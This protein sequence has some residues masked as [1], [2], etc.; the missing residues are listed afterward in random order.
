MSTKGKLTDTEVSDS[1]VELQQVTR[2][3][4]DI[5]SDED[6]Q[7]QPEK[8]QVSN[9]SEKKIRRSERCRT[10]T[11]KGRGMQEEKIKGLKR[12]FNFAYDKWKYSVKFARK[13]L[14]QV[15]E[16]LTDDELHHIISEDHSY[17]ADVQR[18]YDEL[19]QIEL[20]DQETRRRVDLCIQVSN[21][22]SHRAAKQLDGHTFE[23]DDGWPEV[24]SLFN[25][26]VCSL[27]SG[28][29]RSSLHTSGSAERRQEAAAE[30]AASHAV[31]KV[32]QE[33]E[34]EQQEIQRL[35]EE[36]MNKLAEQEA[37]A[38]KRRLEREAEELKR[39]IQIEEEEA[40]IKAQIRAEHAALQRTLDERKRKVQQLET[41]KSLSA[42]QARIEVYDQVEV[43][44]EE[45]DIL[46]G[47]LRTVKQVPASTS[48][49]SPYV[50]SASKALMSSSP[51]STAELVKVLA[52]AVS[53]N[54]IPIPEPVV[55]KG[56]PLM[57]SDWK[58]SF[59]ALIEKKNIN[60]NEKLYY[61]RRYVDG[62]ARKAIEGYFLLG[63]PSAYVAAWELLDERYG[64]PFTIAQSYRDKLH[65]W[66][67]IGPKESLQLRS[68]TDFL[69]SCEAAITHIKALG[70]LN[71]CNENR[72]I[73]SKLPD[74][75]IARWNRMSVEMEE[76]NGHF[77]TFSQF[78]TFLM[79]EVKIACHPITSLQ[80]VK[81]GDADT[82]S[83][84]RNQ[85]M[86]AKVLATNIDE[87]D[88]ITCVFC[89]KKGHTLHTCRTFMKDEVPKRTSFVKENKLCFGCLKPGHY[90]K[91]CSSR[92]ECDVCHKRHP[93][94]L[95]EDRVKVDKNPTQT[96]E[97]Q[98]QGQEEPERVPPEQ[99]TTVAI[100]HRAIVGEAGTIT[101]AILPV[102]LSTTTCPAEEVLVYALL[103]SQ[104]DST[105]I[106]SEVADTLKAKK[107]H[108]KLKLTT[109]TTTSTVNSQK[110]NNL[111][112]RG[113]YSR[114]KISLPP[115]YTREFIPANR[116]HIPT[117]EN[118]KAWSH[119]EHLQE[120]IAPL[121]DCQ[122]GLLI[123]YNCSQALLPREVVSGK[124]NQPYAQR[125]D[126]GWSIVGCG[127]PC[128][129]YGD[130]IGISH[131]MEVRQ[132]TP[133]IESSTSF[134]T[135]VHY[136]S[137]IKV[138]EVTAT[139]IIKVLESDF[140]E[141]AKEE[142]PISQDDLKFL[143]KPKES[144][145]Q[146]VNGHYE[147]PLPFRE[148]RP[149]LPINKTSTKPEQWSYIAS[150][151]FVSQRR[152]HQRECKVGEVSKDDQEL[153]KRFL[154]CT[155]TKEE[156]SLRD[157]LKKFLDWTISP[158]AVARVKRMTKH[159]GFKQRTNVYKYRRKDRSCQK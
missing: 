128:V 45:K 145:T 151:K 147:M 126:L 66:P 79:K 129:D 16:P 110:V 67:K 134:R 34:R 122:V 13:K 137:R 21:F 158:Q 148:E 144:I 15:T 52:D 152:S 125:T 87:K 29:K 41:M 50:F 24:G 112:I 98:S 101:S 53:T 131:H 12:R 1:E 32:S 49:P 116:D 85:T 14:V 92:S 9:T 135:E 83:G 47:E 115:A 130:A 23:E 71:D 95:H 104:S 109:M 73:L 51:E 114:K 30:A 27:I 60:E 28:S 97:K 146:K 81:Q 99:T 142:N 94:C 117:N 54:R 157:N 59:Q 143:S 55:F 155:E 100:A 11:E 3:L 39:R 89:E 31:L 2:Q 62:E 149:E 154:C 4:R 63:T 121:L 18:I 40:K 108:I 132:V 33:Q 113:Y 5:P 153:H 46:G 58:L 56:D 74:W 82:T 78:V 96:K 7:E 102:W 43:A 118:A 103:D 68:Y 90:S 26:S 37:A 10:L 159:N 61:L 44:Q 127:S 133:N 156:R 140:S 111:Q 84:K 19:R 139:E 141:R 20:P 42:A 22:I 88:V 93:T 91:K 38:V 76:Q 86:G 57:Y 107:D 35:Q 77:P 120:R 72:K 36:S 17:A 124:V 106:L 70:I 69:R 80:S 136:V 75:L 150:H 64:N 25:S 119:L 48:P 65:T 138:K 6:F 123:G 105:F 8:S